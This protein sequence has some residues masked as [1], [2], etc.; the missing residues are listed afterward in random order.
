MTQGGTAN[1][2][3]STLENQVISLMTN[4]GFV[5]AKYSDWINRPESYGGELLLKRVPYTSIYGHCAHTEFLIH[6]E[7]HGLDV[8]VECKWQQVTGSVDEKFPY[9]YLNCVERMPELEIIIIVDGGG[10]KPQSTSWLRTVVNER[11]YMGEQHQNK[12]ISVMTLTQFIVWVNRR[13]S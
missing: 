2:F 5:V 4:K 13:F 1:A 8:R 11:R 7:L 10:A 12:S 6:S 3:G 9:L